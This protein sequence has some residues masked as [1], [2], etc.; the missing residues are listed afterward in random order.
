MVNIS[1]KLHVLQC[2]LDYFLQ[3]CLPKSYYK[4]PPSYKLRIT[5]PELAF[6]FF[7]LSQFVSRVQTKMP[8]LIAADAQGFLTLKSR[9]PIATN[10]PNKYGKM[11]RTSW[12]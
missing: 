2:L 8:F 11:Q 10:F 5:R 12:C 7:P 3:E 6:V 9:L 1:L 4:I